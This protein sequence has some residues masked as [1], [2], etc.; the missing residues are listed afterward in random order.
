MQ[1]ESCQWRFPQF[2][3]CSLGKFAALASF[4][5]IQGFFR[6]PIELA[7]FDVALEPIIEASRL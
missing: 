2:V 4:V 3:V 7:F 6:Q 5:L 1:N